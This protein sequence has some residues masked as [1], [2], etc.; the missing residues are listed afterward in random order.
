MSAAFGI[1][2]GATS[3][4]LAACKDGKVD[5]V[6]NEAGDRVTPTVVAFT[7]HELTVGLP[8][9]QGL[10]RNAANTVC[11]VKHLMGRPSD[12][13][14]VQ[15]VKKWS[16]VKVVEKSG[17][18]HYEVEYKEKS[19]I[20]ST[21][22]IVAM[23]YK[24][25]REIAD[26]QGDAGDSHDTVLTV[27]LHFTDK[28][29]NI[30]KISAEKAGLNILRIITEP[31]AAALAYDIGQ[32]SHNEES[33]VLVYRMGGTSLDVTI[34]A[35]SNGLYRVLA[36]E[37]IN[38]VGGKDFTNLLVTH[39]VSEF[40]RQFKMDCSENKRSMAKLRNAS[41]TSKH[42]LST[43]PSAQCSVESLYDGMD[44]QCNISRARFEGLLTGILPTCIEPV[45]SALQKAGLEKEKVEK[46]VLCGGSTKVPLLQKQ[47]KDFFPMADVLSSIAPDEVIAYGAAKQASLL[48]ATDAD[49]L[50]DNESQTTL[51]A[52]PV[53]ILV[54]VLAEEEGAESQNALVIPHSTP[55]P[56]RKQQTYQLR[57][58]QSDFCLQVMYGRNGGEPQVL[59][60]LVM[61]EVAAG[62]L[63]NAVFHAHTD[64][65]LHVTCTEPT[66][67]KS[68]T[69]VIETGS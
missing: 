60:K 56:V 62:S 31:C 44:F 18:P 39:F 25:V 22:D 43:L 65:S 15:M 48:V 4:C 59:A 19:T 35:L 37:H 58:D 52:M 50:K 1:H 32:V 67:S 49:E 27:P 29:R 24:N 68:E 13:P 64:G 41:E 28:Q 55:I 40:K 30:I 2:F 51:P 21:S 23:I 10:I 17:N 42:I 7:D 45:T 36:T 12:D 8:A 5:I 3:A 66:S 53:D 61:Q 9:K 34:L 69:V 16:Q 11:H 33:N 26:S 6:A 47:L 46:V 57:Q 54:Q 20:F 63:I 14:Q 38:N